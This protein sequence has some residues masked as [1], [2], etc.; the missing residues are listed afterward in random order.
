MTKPRFR[1]TQ[2]A[3]APTQQVFGNTQ[4]FAQRKITEYQYRLFKN[5]FFR[6]VFFFAPTTV[7]I[8]YT[9]ISQPFLRQLG[10]NQYNLI[11]LGKTV[12]PISTMCTR[13]TILI[14]KTSFTTSQISRVERN[15]FLL[16]LIIILSYTN[17][18]QL[19]FLL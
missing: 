10:C 8:T 5:C 18:Y 15:Y 16:F 9:K 14:E 17:T 7:G 1:K 6:F 2:L 11:S 3:F 4:L 13:N 12:K 19:H